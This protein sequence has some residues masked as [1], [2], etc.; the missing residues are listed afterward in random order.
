MGRFYLDF[1]KVDI[2]D[3]SEKL[4]VVLAFSIPAAMI[5]VLVV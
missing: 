1:G 2:V 5:G 4:E 3:C